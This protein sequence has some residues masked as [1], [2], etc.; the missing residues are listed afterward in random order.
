[1]FDP[2]ASAAAVHPAA[3]TTAHAPHG[4]IFHELL[5]E[6]NPLQYI[7]VIGTLYRAMTGDTVPEATREAG[8]LIFSFLTG[9]PIGVAMSVG[10]LAAEKATGVDPE[11]IGTRVLAD[12]GIGHT[13]GAPPAV[14]QSS[15]L[16]SQAVPPQAAW[17]AGQLAAYGVSTS[18]AG[19]MH[20]HNEDGSDVLNTLE[21]AR[22]HV[23]RTSA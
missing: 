5:S 9:G 1:M 19:I 13:P 20:L 12:I 23:A 14:Q 7:P 3:A 17:S 21:L 4:G 16:P 2:V 8:S 18:S 22:L 6:L 15:P 11:R 10:T